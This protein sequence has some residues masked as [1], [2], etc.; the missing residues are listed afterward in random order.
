MKNL[1]CISN[2]DL[3]RLASDGGVVRTCDVVAN[4]QIGDKEKGND[5]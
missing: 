2:D 3:D 1:P 5:K 4:V